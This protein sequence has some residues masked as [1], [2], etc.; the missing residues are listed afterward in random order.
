MILLEIIVTRKIRTENILKYL[1]YIFATQTTYKCNLNTILK[2]NAIYYLHRK[3]EISYTGVTFT[4]RYKSSRWIIYKLYACRIQVLL[5]INFNDIL[6]N[7][8]TF[9]HVDVCM[10]EYVN[11]IRYDYLFI[12]L[13]VC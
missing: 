5:Y 3:E 8:S 12:I 10:F 1:K 4:S 11:F 13:N 7:T 9:I 2:L 6:T